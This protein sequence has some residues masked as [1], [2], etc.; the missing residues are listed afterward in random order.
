MKPDSASRPAEVGL[1]TPTSR[2]RLPK[3]G[4]SHFNDPDGV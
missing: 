3:A 4:I 1:D 2:Q